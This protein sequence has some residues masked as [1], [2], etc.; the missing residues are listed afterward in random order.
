M[1]WG[2]GGD[3]CS[4]LKHKMAQVDIPHEFKGDAE[5]VS[6]VEVLYHVDDVVLVI[7]VLQTN[8]ST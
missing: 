2:G 7:A 4:T 8:N 5:M 3:K 6:E 1:G